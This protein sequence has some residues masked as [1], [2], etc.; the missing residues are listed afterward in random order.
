M[1]CARSCVGGVHVFMM[2]HLAIYSVLLNISY[3]ICLLE[4][5][6]YRM[7]CLTGGHVQLVTCMSGH[8]F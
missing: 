8:V 3:W 6:Y 4:G 1:S 2:A 7:A 5:M